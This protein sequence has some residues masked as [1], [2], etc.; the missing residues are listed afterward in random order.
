LTEALAAVQ[1][2][3]E[4]Q[5]KARKQVVS[6]AA[7]EDQEEAPARPAGGGLA[8]IRAVANARS[9]EEELVKAEQ[10]RQ[11]KVD[12]AQKE[13]ER[14]K[15]EEALETE[16]TLLKSEVQEL[17]ELLTAQIPRSREEELEQLLQS[18]KSE[19]QELKDRLTVA[20]LRP[21]AVVE[22]A[23][24]A[25]A[26]EI[27]AA[28]QPEEHASPPPLPPVEPPVLQGPDAPAPPESEP[29]QLPPGISPEAEIE[30]PVEDARKWAQK[31]LLSA[32]E[33]GDL[34]QAF[35][36]PKLR[37]A[38]QS[39]YAT[40]DAEDV[41]PGDALEPREDWWGQGQKLGGEIDR[42]LSPVEKRQKALD[43]AVSRARSGQLDAP[44]TSV[45][46]NLSE[47]LEKA[48]EE[49]VTAAEQKEAI[50][51]ESRRNLRE[52]LLSGLI[53][54]EMQL[55]VDELPSREE[56]DDSRQID[57]VKARIL[58]ALTTGHQN[59]SLQRAVEDVKSWPAA[60][61]AP[62]TE[63]PA[64]ETAAA[65]TP[66]AD[67]PAAETKPAEAPATE[68]PDA[69]APVAETPSAEDAAAETPA[70]EA[71]AAEAAKEE[72]PAP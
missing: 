18:M 62:A 45:Q 2:G 3:V 29:P 69:E 51:E 48:A 11:V 68:T 6:D 61:D 63:A 65:E 17:K 33:S 42:P 46:S 9:E 36:A 35:G 32:M 47:R 19:M 39:L 41:S 8:A 70:A 10:A 7:P 16:V 72:T 24:V 49:E 22:E 4:P 50:S 20:E 12:E 38:P 64:A 15:K 25:E 71:P 60:A 40:A 57:S 54:G 13:E 31:A 67:A 34:E 28:E 43:A 30:D 44:E 5:P 56:T 1:A 59:G 58:S 53:T 21:S 14:R 27:E 55:V 37:A 23:A 26:V 52:Q 66:A